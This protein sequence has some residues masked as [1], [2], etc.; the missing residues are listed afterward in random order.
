MPITFNGNVTI[1]G[2]VEMFDNGSIKITN[3]DRQTIHINQLS[4]FIEKEFKNSPKKEEYIQAANT[5]KEK[6]DPDVLRKA[7]DKFNEMGRELGRGIWVEGFSQAAVQ[8]IKTYL[9]IN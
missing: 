6:S 7:L 2:N 3:N 8:A 5:L 4:N 9:G 1:N